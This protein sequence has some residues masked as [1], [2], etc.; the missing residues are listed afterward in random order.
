MSKL[1][2]KFETLFDEKNDVNENIVAMTF[3]MAC[4]AVFSFGFIIAGS[5]SC[6]SFYPA[7]SFLIGM[8]I[9]LVGAFIFKA[10]EQGTLTGEQFVNATSNAI[11]N[12]CKK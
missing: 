5:L 6:F 12:A 2:D 4:F 11:S 1:K 7:I 3:F 9:C 10:H 8:I